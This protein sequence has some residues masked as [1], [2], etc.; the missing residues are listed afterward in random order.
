MLVMLMMSASYATSPTY[1]TVSTLDNVKSQPIYLG[2][3]YDQYSDEGYV[4]TYDPDTGTYYTRVREI[5]LMHGPADTDPVRQYRD[6]GY[7]Y[8]TDNFTGTLNETVSISDSVVHSTTVSSTVG[9]SLGISAGPALAKVQA[10]VS[11]SVTNSLT[12]SV[13][14]TITKTFSQGY[15]YGF[16]SQYAPAN[17]TKAKRGVGFQYDTYRSIVDIKK[18]VDVLKYVD[19]VKQEYIGEEIRCVICGYQ[20]DDPSHMHD[21]ITHYKFTL[22][23]GSIKYATSEELDTLIANG[24]VTSDMKKWKTMTKEWKVESVEG[25]VLVPA[26]V[27]V[28]VYMDQYGN[29]LDADGNIIYAMTR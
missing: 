4:A 9:A 1:S 14:M 7:V 19:I 24:T 17:C 27:M 6:F 20:C 16:P 23:D 13:G 2:D 8:R 22:A 11:Y 25:E 15:S 29:I 5:K 28:T 18:E 10:T 3:V 12:Q 26:T 21:L